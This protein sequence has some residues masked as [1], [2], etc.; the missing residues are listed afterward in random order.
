MLESKGDGLSL[1]LNVGTVQFNTVNTKEGSFSLMTADGL[2]RS[3]NIGEPNLPHLRK[4]IAIPEG[5]VLKAR[6]VSSETQEL[7]LNDM[8]LTE[9]LMPAQPSLSKSDDP[10]SVPFEFNRSTYLVDDFYAQ[11]TV[12]VEIMGTMRGVRLG[13]ITVNPIAYNPVNNKVRVHT[14]LTVQVD[15]EN[16]DW[17]ATEDKLATGHSPVFEPIFKQ[18]LNYTSFQA[19]AAKDFVDLTKYPVK[20][21]IVSDPMFEAQLQPFIEWK[22]KKGFTVI[23]AY[24]GTGAGQIGTTNTQIKSY[25]QGLYEAGTE[26]DPPPSFVLLVGDAQQI[27]PFDG[28]DGHITDLRFFEFS[29]PADDFPEIYYGRFSAQTTAQLQP[30]IDKTLEYEQYLMPDPSYLANVTLVSGYD[31]YG[32]DLTFG[33]GAINYGSN[34]YF[35]TAHGINANVWLSPASNS[36]TAPADIRQT[37]SDGISLYNYTAHCSHDGHATPSFESSHIPA[38]TNYHK[39]LLGIGNCC[40]PN[41]F[42]TDYSTPCFGEAFLQIAD[43]GGIGYI[44]ATD[45]T[46]WD[47]DYYWAVGYKPVVASGPAYDPN[48]IAA[49]DGMWH[50]HGEP[51]TSHYVTNSAIVF[52]GNIGVTEG[53]SRI[54]YYWESYMLMGDPSLMTYVG[55][56]TENSVSHDASFMFTSTSITVNADP[57]SYV[58]ISMDGVLYGAAFVDSSGSVDVPITAFPSPGT[59]DVVVT[60]QNREPYMATVPVIA[61]SGPYCVYDLHTISDALG[62]NNGLVEPGEDI[63]LGVQLKNVGPDD[64]LDVT[65]TISSSDIYVTITDDTEYYGTIAA[66]NGTGYV[67]DGFAF[68]VAGDIPDGHRIDFDLEVTGTARDTWYG[69]FRVTA[70]GPNVEF[71]SVSINDVAGGNGNGILDPGETADLIVTLTNTGHGNAYGVEAQI[72]ESDQYLSIT[73]DYALYGDLDSVGG[74]ANNSSD[75]FT[76]SADS[77]CPQ[78]YAVNVDL[79]ITAG[80]HTASANFSLTVGDRVVIYFDDF[81]SNQGWTGLG[82][83]GE[84]EMTAPGGLGGDPSDDHTPGTSNGVLGNDLTVGGTYSNNLTQTHWVTSPMLD[85]SQITGL[86]MKYYHW[87]GCERNQYDHV[88]FEVFDGTDWV[89]IWEN[90]NTTLTSSSWTEAN[91][92]LSGYADGNPAFQMRFGIGITDGSGQYAGW[93]IDDIELKGYSGSGSPSLVLEPMS[94][95]DSLQPGDTGEQL[96]KVKNAGDGNLGIWFT[97]DDAWLDFSYD[98]KAI[99]PPGDSAEYTLTIT[100]TGL[101]GG[102]HTGSLSYSSNDGV[103]ASGSIAVSLHIYEPDMMVMSSSIDATVAPDS[104][105]TVPLEIQNNGPGR[106]VYSAGCTM[107]AKS[108]LVPVVA[109]EVIEPLGSRPMGE[110]KYPGQ[111]EEYY[112]ASTK[113]SGGPDAFGYQW[114]DSDEPGGPTYSWIDISTLGTAVTLTDDGTAGPFPIG[115]EFPMYDTPYTQFYISANGMVTFDGSYGS[116]GN[117]P[118]PYGSVNSA[119]I[120]LWWDDLNPANGGDV[121]YYYDATTMQLIISWVAVPN[122]S[123]P[124]GTGDLTFQ[125]VLTPNGRILLQYGRMYAGADADGLAGATIGIQNTAGDIGLQVVHNAQYVHENLAI[126]L[127][128]ASWLV[129]DPPAG[130]IEPFST[131]TVNVV[132]DALGIAE[133]TFGGSVVLGCNDPDSPSMTIPVTMTVSAG[134][135]NGLTGNVDCSA[136][137]GADVGDLTRLIDHLMISFAPLCC[138]EEANTDGDSEGSIDVGDLTKLIDHLFISFATLPACQ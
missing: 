103:N 80:L 136:S 69:S 19:Q 125:A 121:Y 10:E 76:V 18:I 132:F 107:D 23:E 137:E 58:A 41:T 99:I 104:Q 70:V 20:Y 128:T 134:C 94:V 30:Q 44:G 135:C 115:F 91:Y 97:A 86:L 13:R 111:M 90:E 56:P 64:A 102:D 75:V 4:L 34:E 25:I 3:Y 112:P 51:M 84:W 47:E 110:D 16:P 73:D 88:Y 26:I 48:H 5:C 122:Y 2:G 106:L 116:A 85:C 9:L 114:L 89:T 82:G 54:T 37:V 24:T 14:K 15:F 79:G 133:G 101:A 95:S 68:T 35:N 119:M 55:L 52:A 45:N 11:P 83:L 100:T 108:R 98:T 27:P 61:P 42:G 43:K 67:L 28:I 131:G 6:V 87:I 65:A 109:A 31:S 49:F 50:T 7:S 120:A 74:T 124:D 57:E 66:D 129:T 59:A 126:L 92:D 127:Y 62:N 117:N 77:E 39:Y 105:L 46:Y 29:D 60:A 123:Y 71:V 21:L 138:P 63:T 22:T 96:I 118:L 72:T 17:T 53:G 33:N 32:N 81:S 40:T 113:N 1:E 8:G 12:E 93:N 36:G 78:G 130:T 38:L